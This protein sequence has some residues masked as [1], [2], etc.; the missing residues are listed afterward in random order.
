[1]KLV[2]PLVILLLLGVSPLSDT[3]ENAVRNFYS[4]I[5][6]I[7]NSGVP[8]ENELRLF[9]PFMS[10]RLTALIQNAIACRKQFIKD[11]PPQIIGGILSEDKPPFSDG[12]IFSSNIEGITSYKLGNS[13]KYGSE[14]R[15]DLHLVHIDPVS[16]DK[17]SW[18]DVVYVI[19]EVNRFVVDDI[20]FMG[21]WDYGNH[22]L[23]SKNLK[24]NMGK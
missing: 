4:I 10:K 5:V 8:S 14:Y 21:V 9:A 7:P 16:S 2:S 12:N 22:G 23:L 11:N 1:M 24:C 18:I 13:Y 3:P 15:I 19:K 20:Q 17:T 6:N